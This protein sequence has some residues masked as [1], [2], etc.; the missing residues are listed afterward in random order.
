MQTATNKAR[1]SEL[2]LCHVYHCETKVSH[3]WHRWNSSSIQCNLTPKA[4]ICSW[5]SM[6]TYFYMTKYGNH[7][8]HNFT[9]WLQNFTTIRIQLAL[10]WVVINFADISIH[11]Q[12]Q[13]YQKLHT[14]F[15]PQDVAVIQLISEC[16]K[17]QALWRLWPQMWHCVPWWTDNNL[18]AESYASNFR[19]EDED[20][21]FLWNVITNYIASHPRKLQ[22]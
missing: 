12:F 22:S 16:K 11:M 2:D 8:M 10:E 14:I 5:P 21:L 15:Y 17:R 20:I 13:S 6:K 9:V 18:L 1:Y 3:T 19:A 7:K 4:K